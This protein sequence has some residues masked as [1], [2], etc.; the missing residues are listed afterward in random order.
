MNRE[1]Q[2]HKNVFATTI[3]MAKECRPTGKEGPSS[4]IYNMST[5]DG[6]INFSTNFK[7]TYFV[8]VMN[9]RNNYILLYSVATCII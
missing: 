6:A 5:L 8:M 2:L 7:L 9:E 3:A 4:R 1:K